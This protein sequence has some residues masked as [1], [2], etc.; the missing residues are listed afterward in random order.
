MIERI[1]EPQLERIGFIA[2][3]APSSMDGMKKMLLKVIRM[4]GVSK[5][6]T[7][8]ILVGGINQDHIDIFD[9]RIRP[10]GRKAPN[11]DPAFP[12]IF[13][14]SDVVEA[15][16]ATRI[17]VSGNFQSLQLF[18]PTW[19][20][21]QGLKIWNINKKGLM[22]L[23]QELNS[24]PSIQNDKVMDVL[25]KTYEKNTMNLDAMEE[26]EVEDEVTRHCEI[27]FPIMAEIGKNGNNNIMNTRSIGFNREWKQ[28][29]Q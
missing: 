18:P 3:K 13:L 20:P 4:S 17:I 27:R 7:K 19:T 29:Q 9:T 10:D 5:L 2:S 15:I 11:S 14:F 24:L 12:T 23:L 26:D 22:L 6:I 25:E 1:T 16:E 28:Q 21:L 8:A